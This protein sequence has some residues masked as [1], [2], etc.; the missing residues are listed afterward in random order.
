MFETLTSFLDSFLAMGI[1]GID[2]IVK[3]HGKTIYRHFNGYADRERKLPMTG[4]ELYNVYSCSKIITCTALLQLY[5]KGLFKLDDKLSDYMPEFAQMSIRTDDGIVPAKNPITIRHLF[6]MTAGFSYNLR[7]KGLL[8][9][10]KDTLGRCPTR[11]AI[12]YLAQDPLYFEP[13]TY[14]SYS[15]CHDVL[16]ALAEV[17]TGRLFNDVVTEGIFAPL[18]MT[19][20]TY[21]PSA[22]Q[23]AAIA[24]QY[25]GYDNS[26]TIALFPGNPYRLG[27]EYCSGGAGCVSTVADFS[28]FLEALRKG[29]V[30]LGKDTIAL[31]TTDQLN[32][33]T[34]KGLDAFGISD[35]GYGLGVRCKR[36][37]PVYQ[38]SDF[39]W[40]G[41]A[42]AYMGVD[43]PH[44]VSFHF[45]EHVL[46]APNRK[47]RQR[48]SAMIFDELDQA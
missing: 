44:D 26:D 11:E 6:T 42:A 23:Y 2:C 30:I 34:R 12:R 33:D 3:Q 38:H 28:A 45:G 16:V 41:A 29:D 35:Y 8:Q 21:M 24:P 10:R 13:G 7:T 20:S 43:L 47:L 17:L 46:S 14:W 15:L 32:D 18:G 36:A 25:H 9:C 40:G 48:I 1:P 19:R 22:E 4:E 39:G 5:E 27:T 31:M 37:V